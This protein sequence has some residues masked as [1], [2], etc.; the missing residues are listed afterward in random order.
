MDKLII[1]GAGGHGRVVKDIALS[2]NKYKEISFLD[3][4][5]VGTS[6]VGKVEDFSNYIGDSEFIVAIGNNDIR[7][8]IS[9]LIIDGGAKLTSLIH[10]NAVI[11]GEV[12]IGDGSVVMAGV[13]INNG[14]KIGQG[15]IVNTCSSIDHDCVVKNYSHVSVGA[16]IAG[17]VSIDEK[18][19]VGAGAT[20]IN[21]VSVVS[22]TIIG[23]GAVVVKDIVKCGTYVGVPAK[24][25]KA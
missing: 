16:R 8:K 12:N 14:A 17:T 1:I 6:V 23:A 21:N 2:L 3:D 9:N 11:G 13:V 18:V 15:V 25:V 24:I 5:A 20:I 22:K 19:F 10:S 4:F 7:Q